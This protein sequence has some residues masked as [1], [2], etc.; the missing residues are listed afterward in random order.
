VPGYF[1][2][3]GL[4][5]IQTYMNDNATLMVPPYNEE[6]QRVHASLRA[7]FSEQGLWWGISR[8]EAQ[9]YFVAGG[10][11]EG[12]FDQIWGQLLQQQQSEVD[13]AARGDLHTA[14]GDIHY[15]V[16]GRRA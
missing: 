9:R 13:A 15:I 8:D 3:A 14:G 7:G 5:R 1:A 2:A 4:M 10:G 6:G 12:E 16:G 11:I